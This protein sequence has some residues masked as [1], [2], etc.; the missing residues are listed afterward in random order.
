MS[1][2]AGFDSDTQCGITLVGD[3]FPV[4]GRQWTMS[5]TCAHGAPGWTF[6]LSG[7]PTAITYE[8]TSHSLAWTAPFDAAGTV[9]FNVT[10]VAT[11]PLGD[12]EMRVVSVEPVE[13]LDVALNVAADPLAYQTE[14][15][16]PILW[17][18]QDPN[19]DYDAWSPMTVTH[20]GHVYQAEAHYRGG[21]S[22]RYPKR[23]VTIEFPRDDHFEEPRYGLVDRKKLLLLTTFNDNSYLRHRVCFDSWGEFAQGRLT[24]LTGSAVVY[25]WD[26]QANRFAYLGLYTISDQVNLGFF[27]RQ[28][29]TNT[30]HLYKGASFD[31]T[32]GLRTSNGA[33]K[34]PPWSGWLKKRGDPPDGMPGAYDPIVE[35]S[36]FIDDASAATFAAQIDRRIDLTEFMDWWI[37][38]GYHL[39][40]DNPSHNA[41][42]YSPGA[43]ARWR[44][45]PWDPDGS[46]G[47]SPDTLRQGGESVAEFA[48]HNRIFARII[49]D[50]SLYA[51]AKARFGDMVTTGALRDAALLARVRAI[52]AE[53]LPAALRDESVWGADFRAFDQW[54]HVRML[55]NSITTHEEEVEYIER[56]IP[57]RSRWLRANYL[58]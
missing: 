57:A 11:G 1:I 46:L 9:A 8:A 14:H 18:R 17:L 31:A 44:Y 40:W 26:H 29:V 41:Y 56:W 2:D 34:M 52:A 19:L 42:V 28:G 23:S 39:L 49:A 10:V 21:V 6:T 20:L 37:F 48:E 55:R 30:G 51:T 12:V 50:P 36:R 38:I 43:N 5:V 4:E 24:P 15:G 58:P 33:E 13:S 35:L 27:D 25:M 54:G 7:Y 32:F 45:V 22:R 3:R 53:V 16:L 47:Q